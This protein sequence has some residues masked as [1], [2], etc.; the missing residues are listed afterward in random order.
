MNSGKVLKRYVAFLRGINVG[1]HHKIK[2]AAL[3]LLFA[4]LG[5][6]HVITYIQSGNVIFNAGLSQINKKCGTVLKTLV[7]ENN[8]ILLQMSVACRHLP[9]NRNCVT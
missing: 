4:D 7:N 8:D 5:F 3:K 1:G 6:E 2:M 9:L